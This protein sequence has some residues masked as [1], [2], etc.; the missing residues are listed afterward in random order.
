MLRVPMP[1][2]L[3]SFAYPD[4]FMPGDVVEEAGEA[5]DAGGVPDHAGVEPH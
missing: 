2:D 1:R 3:N 4:M 5:G